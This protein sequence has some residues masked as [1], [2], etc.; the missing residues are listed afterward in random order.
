MIESHLWQISEY[1]DDGDGVVSAWFDEKCRKNKSFRK[2]QIRLQ[3]KL[4]MIVSGGPDLVVKAIAGSDISPHID[5]I[6]VSGR[7]TI[8]ALF[9]R[10]PAMREVTLVGA[11]IEKGSELIEP[12][13]EKHSKERQEALASGTGKR[14]KYVYYRP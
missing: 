4:D 2:L 3:A 11:S 12:G 7:L 10:G 1:D 9:V 6:R 13:I 14:K 8:R 5:K